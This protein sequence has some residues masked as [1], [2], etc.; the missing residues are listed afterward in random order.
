[1]PSALS[2]WLQIWVS[3]AYERAFCSDFQTM[4]GWPEASTKTRG[5]TDPPSDCSQM[6]GTGEAM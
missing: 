1:M 3:G 2:G 5:S 4:Q 6:N